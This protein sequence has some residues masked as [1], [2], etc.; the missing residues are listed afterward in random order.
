M[1]LPKENMS[2]FFMGPH[3]TSP[4]PSHK[5]EGELGLSP[6]FMPVLL[7]FWLLLLYSWSSGVLS[8]KASPP[9][10]FG[11]LALVLTVWSAALLWGWLEM[12]NLRP[13][14]QPFESSFGLPK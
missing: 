1:G 8:G 9:F 5:Q 10:W 12:L 11:H 13:Y 14:P 3:S 6:E 4:G 2:V 7:L